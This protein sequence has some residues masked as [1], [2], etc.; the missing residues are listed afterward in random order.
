M[1]SNTTAYFARKKIISSY[2]L[3]V[4][5]KGKAHPSGACIDASLLGK[6]FVLPTNIRLP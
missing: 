6:L 5:S 3:I 2:S 1:L 4:A